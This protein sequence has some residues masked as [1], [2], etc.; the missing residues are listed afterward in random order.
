MRWLAPLT[1]LAITAALAAGCGSG[2]APRRAA[3]TAPLRPISRPREPA[4]G[5]L[6]SIRLP[7]AGAT[8]RGAVRVVVRVRGFGLRKEGGDT[9]RQIHFSLD[10]GRYDEPQY[11]GL[12]ACR[13]LAVGVN[14]RYSIA[15]AQTITYRFVSAGT[16][17]LR[18]QLAIGQVPVGK[19][20]IVTF[21]TVGHPGRPSEGHCVRVRQP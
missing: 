12:P 15:T 10:D 6:I 16:H 1:W 7:V 20:A 14:G 8:V 21:R 19:E 3:P 13:A 11:A 4:L 9:G 17:T 5:T 18:A 2:S